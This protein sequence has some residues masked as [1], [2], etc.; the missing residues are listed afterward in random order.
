M[1]HEVVDQLEDGT[2]EEGK[3][4]CL[5]HGREDADLV[6]GFLLLARLYLDIVGVP[7]E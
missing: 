7:V 4:K 3:P 2:K 5:H 1:T 6:L